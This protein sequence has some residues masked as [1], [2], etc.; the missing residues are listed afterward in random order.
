MPSHVSA[1][2]QSPAVG[3][4]EAPALANLSAGQSA[5]VPSQISATSHRSAAGRQTVPAGKGLPLARHAPA[6]TSMLEM[7]RPPASSRHVP[8]A[9]HSATCSGFVRFTQPATK[10]KMQIVVSTLAISVPYLTAVSHFRWGAAG[11]H[12]RVLYTW[13]R[14]RF[15]TIKENE[16]RNT[17]RFVALSCLPLCNYRLLEDAIRPGKVFLRTTATST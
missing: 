10:P 1:M 16:S 7:R 2:S 3:R 9:A 13:R 6:G 8:W 15:G 4:H 17:F 14:N 11:P 12:R 5:L